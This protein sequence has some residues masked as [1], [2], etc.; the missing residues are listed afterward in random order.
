MLSF[1]RWECWHGREIIQAPAFRQGKESSRTSMLA[2]PKINVSVV[3]SAWT[4]GRPPPTRFSPP[5]SEL[6]HV[7]ILQV[8]VNFLC[9]DWSI[10]RRPVID[11]S[12]S[13]TVLYR[14][15][16]MQTHKCQRTPIRCEKAMLFTFD[17]IGQYSNLDGKSRSGIWDFVFKSNS[18]LNT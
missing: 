10:P 3:T 7:Y 2:V 14:L 17:A 16:L 4:T 12:S 6:S 9:M 1:R 13:A 11:A 15:G 8:S 18:P 5:P